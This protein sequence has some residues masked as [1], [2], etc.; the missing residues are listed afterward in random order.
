[1]RRGGDAVCGARATRVIAPRGNEHDD[2]PADH[3]IDAVD[4]LVEVGARVRGADEPGDDRAG[5]KIEGKNDA[6]RRHVKRETR[7]EVRVRDQLLTRDRGSRGIPDGADLDHAGHAQ[8]SREDAEPQVGPPN[9][10]RV[11]AQLDLKP[12]TDRR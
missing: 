12:E 11:E 10:P 9:P 4:V 3:R 7:G 1:M 8:M 5:P 6:A 2:A